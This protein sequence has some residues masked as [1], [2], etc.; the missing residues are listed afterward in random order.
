VPVVGVDHVWAVGDVTGIA[1]YTHTAV[2]QGRI[3]VAN[4]SGGDA[5]ADYRAIPPAV[6][7]PA[8]RGRGR[9]H[10]TERTRS[11]DRPAGGDGI[12]RRHLPAVTEGDREGWVRLVADPARGL[13]VGATA[14][15]SWAEEWISE[16][17]LAIRAEVPLRLAQVPG[18]SVLRKEPEAMALVA[19]LAR[20]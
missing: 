16:L 2:Y 6:Y 15:G 20:D 8:S 3:V 12:G 17:V 18:A 4:L 9:A 1:P 19:E 14:V 7:T 11:R 13:L 5:G 10:R